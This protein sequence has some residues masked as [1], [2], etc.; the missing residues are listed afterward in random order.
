MSTSKFPANLKVAELRLELA[1]RNLST[2]G[3]KKELTDR[4]EA[5]LLLEQQQNAAGPDSLQPS[6]AAPGTLPTATGKDDNMGD[7]GDPVESMIH[8]ES[9]KAPSENMATDAKND[10]P[11]AAGQEDDHPTAAPSKHDD[12]GPT[13]DVQMHAPSNPDSARPAVDVGMHDDLAPTTPKHAKTPSKKETKRAKIARQEQEAAA[14]PPTEV[15]EPQ[16][17]EAPLPPPP[18][19]EPMAEMTNHE[20]EVKDTM[21]IDENIDE[22][23]RKRDE[24][25]EERNGQSKGLE[26]PNNPPAPSIEPSPR[27]PPA[28]KLRRF[29]PANSTTNAATHNSNTSP[30][31]K[32]LKTEE[33]EEE[34]AAS[35]DTESLKKIIQTDGSAVTSL[36][37]PAAASNIH[38][39]EKTLQELSPAAT[40]AKD[41]RT[42]GNADDSNAGSVSPNR[43][44]TNSI[45][46]K[47]F[48]RPLTQQ[49]VKRL[50][51][52]YGEVEQLWIDNIKTHCYVTYTTPAAAKAAR[53][54]IHDIKFPADTGRQLHV[55]LVPSDLVARMIPE[56]E[57]ALQER[58]KI[59]WEAVLL[60]GGPETRDEGQKE[61]KEI[62]FS[63]VPTEPA[64]MR[65]RGRLGGNPLGLVQKQLQK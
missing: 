46:I 33:E 51:G 62:D 10:M 13:T 22:K 63:T 48:V 59:D 15:L 49:Q 53:A 24:E 36:S 60:N 16:V 40:E 58:R 31:P 61:E 55:G 20:K 19:E 57:R 52:Q 65:E 28:K 21:E 50:V 7:K 30:G 37:T 32:N 6:M 47:G 56:E 1:S 39:D 11:Q 25:D 64:A 5:A 41:E 42:A 34:D 54:A 35:V 14:T 23:K 4:L 9:Q 17:Q 45:Y 3:L 29:N 8:V 27:I 44:P 12:A 18:K 38:P 26:P 43:E 2:K